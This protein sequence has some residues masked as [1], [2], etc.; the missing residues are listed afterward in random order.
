MRCNYRVFFRDEGARQRDGGI[1][2]DKHRDYPEKGGGYPGRAWGGDQEQ[3]E[4]RSGEQPDEGYRSDCID[5]EPN[6]A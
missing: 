6:C 4:R 5:D 3:Q 2:P 1:C